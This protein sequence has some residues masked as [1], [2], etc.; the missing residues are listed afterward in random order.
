[1]QLRTALIILYLLPLSL[2][3]Q[4]TEPARVNGQ[5]YTMPSCDPATQKITWNTSEK[6]WECQTD[7]QGSGGLPSGLLVFITSGTCP[8]GFTEDVTL[9]GKTIIITT[10]AHGDVGTT[11]GVD[12][13]TPA[14]SVSQPIFT[15]NAV[16]SS[17]VSGGTP[18]GTIAWP[19]SVPTSST[20]TATTANR[21]SGSNAAVTGPTSWT[22]TITWPAAVPI[23]TGVALATHKHSTT[24]TGTV[25]QPAFNGTQFDN[26]SSFKK[27]IACEKD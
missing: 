8:T 9:D 7:Q 15:G 6:K 17:L 11:G 4:E 25:S 18:S 5:A 20:Y 14:G 26:R 24:A 1:M 21:G 10:T 12:S 22:P 2:A 13:I 3:A 19:G 23:F 16:D 27:V